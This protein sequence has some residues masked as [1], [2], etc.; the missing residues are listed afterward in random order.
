MGWGARENV[1]GLGG[2]GHIIILAAALGRGLP[3]LHTELTLTLTIMATPRDATRM[4]TEMRQQE[5][6][7]VKDSA[8]S[9]TNDSNH[10]MVVCITKCISMSLPRLMRSHSQRF[11]GH[12]IS[13]NVPSKINLAL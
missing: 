12:H 13:V 4:A 8:P 9:D 5:L 2:W 11:A 10:N 3:V 6:Q 1:H 7:N